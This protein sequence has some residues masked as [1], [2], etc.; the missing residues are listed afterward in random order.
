MVS[1][2]LVGREEDGEVSEF[3]WEVG[4]IYQPDSGPCRGHLVEIIN[5]DVELVQKGV[6]VAREDAQ[7]G[8]VIEVEP[9]AVEVTL[10]S[11]FVRC[12]DCLKSWSFPVQKELAEK[13][14]V[15]RPSADEY[16]D[17][18]VD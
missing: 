11:V 16:R 13:D 1:A 15:Y 14:V 2:L 4:L 3:V 12:R 18:R 17:D 6:A 9:T 7:T 10:P 5:A 8:Q